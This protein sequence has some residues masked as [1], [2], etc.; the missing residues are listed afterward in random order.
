MTEKHSHT[1]D[2]K[3]PPDTAQGGFG[4]IPNGIREKN[5]F[6]YHPDHLGS[7]S[8]ITGQDGKVS[9]HTEYIAF[10]E[11][12]FDEHS[13]EHTM[14]YLFNGKELDQETGLYYYGARYYDPKVSIFVNVD[15]LAEK[16]MQAYAYANNNPV[17]FIDPTGMASEWHKDGKGNLIADKGDNAKT[18]REYLNNN[19]ENAKVSETAANRLYKTMKN[20]KVNINQLNP[21]TLNQNLFGYNYPGPDNPRKYNG[22]SDYSI[23]PTEIEIPAYIHDK[24]YDKVGAVGAKGLFLDTRTIDADKKFVKSMKLLEIKYLLEKDFKKMIQA[25]IIGEGLNLFSSPKQVINEVNNGFK[26]LKKEYNNF[27]NII[28]GAITPP[29]SLTNPGF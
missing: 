5:I 15:P 22:E 21:E 3:P 1:H 24:D 2:H 19:Y 10:G 25:K 14:P 26:I 23:P 13:S 7:S 4:F 12:L 9:Q 8:Y 17:R 11:I 16:T 28:L 27:K 29:A 20:G 6:F 18:L